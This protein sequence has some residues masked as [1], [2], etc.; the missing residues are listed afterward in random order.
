MDFESI[1]FFLA[2][3]VIKRSPRIIVIIEALFWVPIYIVFTTQLQLLDMQQSKTCGIVHMWFPS[4]LVP[5]KQHNL[6]NS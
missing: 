6:Y 3:T 4:H 1:T 5:E 2:F